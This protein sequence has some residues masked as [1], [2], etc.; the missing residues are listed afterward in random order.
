MPFFAYLFLI[1]SFFDR[2]ALDSLLYQV[3]QSFVAAT[4]RGDAA[5]ASKLLTEDFLYKTHRATTESLA[6][7]Q[8]RLSTKVPAPSKV[9]KEL[10]CEDG[11][12]VRE[13]I[14]KPIPFVTVGVR[15]EFDVECPT[16]DECRLTRA[17]FIKQSGGKDK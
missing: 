17:E 13:I 3:V 16:E 15:Q 6:D 5:A 12:F 1:S 7:A 9:T 2:L 8:E 14:V 10:H 11:T 4:E